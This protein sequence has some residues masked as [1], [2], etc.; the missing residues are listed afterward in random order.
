VET[1]V[2]AGMESRVESEDGA[3]AEGWALQR[4][5]DRRFAAYKV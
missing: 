5:R 4:E 1:G 3:V 2:G